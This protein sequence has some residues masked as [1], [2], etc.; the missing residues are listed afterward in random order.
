MAAEACDVM[1]NGTP[2]LAAKDSPEL[3]NC[4]QQGWAHGDTRGDRV[5]LLV[6]AGGDLKPKQS[7]AHAGEI[8]WVHEVRNDNKAVCIELLTKLGRQA[9][10]KA[11]APRSSKGVSETDTSLM[12][13]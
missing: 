11:F 5:P 13:A 7:V 2:A 4:N 8:C 12:E 9:P 6:R 1:E 10:S 3:R